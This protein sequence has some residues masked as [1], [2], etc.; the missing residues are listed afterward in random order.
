MTRVRTIIPC[1]RSGNELIEGYRLK[2]GTRRY[3]WGKNYH[4][5]VM[6]TMFDLAD[7]H[8]IITTPTLMKT[9]GYNDG[10][11]YHFTIVVGGM[12]RASTH[13]CVY[14]NTLEDAFDYAGNMAVMLGTDPYPCDLFRE[15]PAVA[16]MDD[17]FYYVVG[18]S[19][20]LSTP[21]KGIVVSLPPNLNGI[22]TV[23]EKTKHWPSTSAF[24]TLKAK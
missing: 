3:A 24:V 11:P 18:R 23:L 12:P 19:D 5:D 21:D 15:E 16:V 2:D 9:L 6:I 8:P 14:V 20:T 4:R 10:F 1:V 17:G 22:D 7:G 13:R